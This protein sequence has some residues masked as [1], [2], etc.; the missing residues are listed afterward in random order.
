MSA[1][2]GPVLTEV[3]D[4]HSGR[5]RVRGHLTAQGADLVRGTVDSLLRS[6]HSRVVVD[7]RQLDGADDEGLSELLY[8]PGVR[9]RG[10]GFHGGGPAR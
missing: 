8:A 6:G 10:L 7:V 1:V 5:V 9:L 4:R 3:V 2:P